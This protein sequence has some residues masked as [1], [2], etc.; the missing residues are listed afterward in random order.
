MPWRPYVG[1]I[2]ELPLQVR[3]STNAGIFQKTKLLPCLAGSDL[4]SV[5]CRLSKRY[6]IA[7]SQRPEI[8]KPSGSSCKLEPAEVF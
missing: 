3:Y 8:Q 1:A 7:Q 2:H 5:P 4:Q 6:P